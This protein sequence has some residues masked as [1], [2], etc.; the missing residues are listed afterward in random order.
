MLINAWYLMP[1]GG[2]PSLEGIEFDYA[3]L[4]FLLKG[5]SPGI[6]LP[7]DNLADQYRTLADSALRRSEIHENDV[8]P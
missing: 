6:V 1:P 5:E 8:L 4:A 2:E 7:L 3:A